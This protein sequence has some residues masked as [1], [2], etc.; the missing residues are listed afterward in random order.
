MYMMCN[1]VLRKNVANKTSHK[2]HRNLNIATKKH[3][4]E[5]QTK[6]A[7]NTLIIYS[8]IRFRLGL[9]RLCYVRLG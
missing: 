8:Q 9:V 3:R 2:K 1:T 5:K 7:A 6:N 4:T